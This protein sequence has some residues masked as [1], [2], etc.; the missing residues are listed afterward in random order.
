MCPTCPS[1]AADATEEAEDIP[2]EL[3]QAG[4]PSSRKG[5]NEDADEDAELRISDSSVE[6]HPRRRQ[7][8]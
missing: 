8:N 5:N 2:E 1:T 3:N 6:N 7:R 4:L